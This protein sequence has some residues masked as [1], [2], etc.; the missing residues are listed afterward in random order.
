[1]IIGIEGLANAGKTFFMTK[2]LRKEWKR[3]ECIYPNYH[4]FFSETNEDI[5]KWHTLSEIYHIRK[6][7][8]SID[9]GSILFDNQNWMR[10]PQQFKDLI[11]K[12]RHHMVDVVVAMQNYTDIDI[13]LRKNIH[14]L[15]TCECIFRIPK[16]EKV[17]PL[18]QITTIQK[19]KR[20]K[21][22]NI[23]AIKL[24]PA[25]R[26]KRLMFISVLW[27]KVRYDTYNDMDLEQIVCKMI[28]KN[29]KPALKVY[30]REMIDRGRK[31]L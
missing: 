23:N 20:I 9:E 2:F 28:I 21:D 10:L 5:K 31:R 12:H 8:I 4:L 22:H 19:F 6:G 15:Y 18:L 17:K 3:G 11:A 26:V 7:I 1:M 13:K 30:S 27:S 24:V 14:V 25:W 29:N 16:N